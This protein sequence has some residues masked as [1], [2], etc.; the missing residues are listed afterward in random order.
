MS[1]FV[2]TA[3]LIGDDELSDQ[4]IQR[5]V[6]EYRENRVSKIGKHGLSHCPSLKS[7]DIPCVTLLQEAAFDGCSGLTEMILPAVE[8]I[9]TS[10]LRRC[11]NLKTLDTG[12]LKEL[13]GNYIF[14]SCGCLTALILRGDRVCTLAT[15]GSN[16]YNTP[17]ANGSGYI[18]VPSARMA[19][20][21]AAT[22]WSALAAQ[23]RA[24]EDYTVDG[25]ITGAMTDGI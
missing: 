7:V 8:T 11:S 1:T 25:T 20:Y 6:T 9:D 15:L 16:F 23:F 21:Q 10:G 12:S 4:L 17:I 2:N 24:L 22:N 14:D 3:D 19:Q 5:T 18:Y 13:N